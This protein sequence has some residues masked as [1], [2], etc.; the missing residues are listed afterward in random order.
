MSTKYGVQGKNWD[1]LGVLKDSLEKQIAIVIN[2]STLAWT[3]DPKNADIRQAFFN[4]GFISNSC[5]CCR[6]SPA[7]K[8]Q[9]V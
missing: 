8:M 3:L 4:L 1:E 2:G 6:V 7:Q 5:I 9:V